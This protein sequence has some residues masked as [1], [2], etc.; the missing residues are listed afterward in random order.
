M[1]KRQSEDDSDDL[2]LDVISALNH[3][4]EKNAYGFNEEDPANIPYW[5]ST[6]STLL[7]YAISN[8]RDGGIPSCR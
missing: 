6:G 5:I 7:D 3:K 8:R 4:K 2:T 1:R